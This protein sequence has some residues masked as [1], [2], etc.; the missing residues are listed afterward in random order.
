MSLMILVEVGLETYGH[1]VSDTI[2]RSKFVILR[3]LCRNASLYG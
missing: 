1:T 2:L 3:R